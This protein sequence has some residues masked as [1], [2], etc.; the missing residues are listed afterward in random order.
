MNNL[1]SATHPT[2]TSE[3]VKCLERHGSIVNVF[4]PATH[5]TPLSGSIRCIK[6]HTHFDN[7]VKPVL[8]MLWH[9]DGVA[10][11]CVCKIGVLVQIVYWFSLLM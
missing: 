8:S 9:R 3:S 2:S 10:K 5:P 4:F 6:D 11:V 7:I 1:H